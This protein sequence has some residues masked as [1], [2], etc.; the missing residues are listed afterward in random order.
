MAAD[1]I[2]WDLTDSPYCMKARMV[3]QLKGVPYRR[4]TLTLWNRRELVRLSPIGKVPVLVRGADVIA[5]STDIVQAIDAAVPEPAL[6]P[7]DP[8]A[9]AFCD[10]VEDWADESLGAIANACKWVNPANRSAALA[11]TVPEVAGGLPHALVARALVVRVLGRLRRAG[12]TAHSLEHLHA[13]LRASLGIVAALLG[14]R[15]FLLG[16]TPTLADVAVFAP[17]AFLRPYTEAA[18]VRDVPAVAAWCARL[19]DVPA[20]AAAIA[21]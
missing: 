1:A 15:D 9:R 6:R 16:R 21:D 14:D 17:L 5:D 7:R 10:L 4:L 13:R 8:E 18:L 12:V 2:L 19:D 11:R 20:I 3:L